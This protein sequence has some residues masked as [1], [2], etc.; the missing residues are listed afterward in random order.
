MSFNAVISG[1]AE[2]ARENLASIRASK[3]EIL[4]V[5]HHSEIAHWKDIP[6]AV[7]WAAYGLM[8]A[9]GILRIFTARIGGELVGYVG[10]IVYRNPKYRTSLQA[11]QDV[12][13]VV[14]ECR[15]SR[16]GYG[17]VAYADTMLAAEGVQAAF[18]CSK[19]AHPIDALLERQGYSL[20][21]RVW[22]KRY[23][24]GRLHSE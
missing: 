22:A 16:V 6:V 1:L 10:F 19:V 4:L 2:F 3:V 11:L 17:L 20:I 7:D 13:F 5:R 18:Q 12:L 15:G 21:E 9:N 14:P 8:E 24:D 23:D